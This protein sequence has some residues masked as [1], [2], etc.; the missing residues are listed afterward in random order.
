MSILTY[1]QT[2]ESTLPRIASL[3][4]RNALLA[5]QISVLHD[6]ILLA[7]VEKLFE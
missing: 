7:E 3:T 4:E 1:L 2:P 5:A 6:Q